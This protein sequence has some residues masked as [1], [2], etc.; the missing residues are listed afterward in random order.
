LE[1]E[2]TFADLILSLKHSLMRLS[3]LLQLLCIIRLHRMLEMQVIAADIPA[4]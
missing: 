1:I 2:I 4:A 3:M